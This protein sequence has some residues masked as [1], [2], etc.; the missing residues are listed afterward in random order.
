MAESQEKSDTECFIC[1]PEGILLKVEN[2]KS[3]WAKISFPVCIKHEREE[4]Q[5]KIEEIVANGEGLVRKFGQPVN[6]RRSLTSAFSESYTWGFEHDNSV[7]LR[8]NTEEPNDPSGTKAQSS[9]TPDSSPKK[10]SPSK[11]PYRQA[12][13]LV[14]NLPPETNDT[15]RNEPHLRDTEKILQLAYAWGQLEVA[16]SALST[17]YDTLKNFD[18]QQLPARSLK[19]RMKQVRSI[20][21]EMVAFVGGAE[22][23]D[24]DGKEVTEQKGR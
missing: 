8:N 9:L 22:S 18:K 16:E 24:E 15:S 21:K 10:Q 3:R 6:L 23:K 7:Q 2:G 12:D 19:Q 5:K 17:A 20:A 13:Y 14:Q 11:Q 4:V 1:C